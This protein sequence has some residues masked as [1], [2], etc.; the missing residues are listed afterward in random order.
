MADM[1]AFRDSPVM[2]YV[3]KL[4]CSVLLPFIHYKT[5]AVRTLA[6]NPK[7]APVCFIN[8]S[9]ETLGKGR[10]LPDSL[11][12]LTTKPCLSNFDSI[13]QRKKVFSAIL[14]NA[15]DCF[16]MPAIWSCFTTPPTFRTQAISLNTILIEVGRRFYLLTRRAKLLVYD[17]IGHAVYVSLTRFVNGVTTARSMRPTSFEP[18]LF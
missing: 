16:L 15:R 10:I 11:T 12:R 7:P 13:G 18:F 9:P 2:Q 6:R 4:V 14:A 5:V 1:Q 17:A 8:V 3:G